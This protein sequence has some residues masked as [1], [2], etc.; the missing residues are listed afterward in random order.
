MSF[1]R[2]MGTDDGDDLTVGQ[3]DKMKESLMSTAWHNLCVLEGK[4]E[5]NV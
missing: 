2:D 5:S 1:S 3:R 4:Q